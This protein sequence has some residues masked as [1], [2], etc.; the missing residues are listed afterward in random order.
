M[1]TDTG[2]AVLSMMI[3][4]LT[5]L[6]GFFLVFAGR[7]L[8]DVAGMLGYLK[9]VVDRIDGGVDKSNE[10][11]VKRL[12]QNIKEGERDRRWM[13]GGTGVVFALS[14][15][16]VFYVMTVLGQVGDDGWE[17][18]VSACWVLFMFSI[19]CLGGILGMLMMV[20]GRF[21]ELS[22]RREAFLR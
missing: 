12:R 20:S 22:R 11:S 9:G 2:I 17:G 14:I 16:T 7:V 19:V 4:V 18:L 8:G 13:E 1:E 21:V 5:F 15:V 6:T 3:T 10:D